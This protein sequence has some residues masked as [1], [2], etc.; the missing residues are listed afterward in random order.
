MGQKKKNNK[1]TDQQNETKKDHETKTT[2]TTVVLKIDMHC[3]GCTSK[4]IRCLRGFQ[5]LKLTLPVEGVEKLDVEK[6]TGK[7]T[8]TGKVD[9][10]KLRDKLASKMKK[11]VDL[12]SPLP[13]ENKSQN[14]NKNKP[15][16]KKSKQKE[17]P[18]TTAVL[19]MELHC[20]GCIERIRKT[21]SKAKGVYHVEIDK[22][23]ETVTV[24]GTM[25]VKALAGSLTERLKRKVEV[26]PTKKEKGNEKDGDKKEKDGDKKENDGGK[27]NKQ[28]GEG[29]GG[30]KKGEND[31]GDGKG[32]ME[33]LT[34][35]CGY[36]YG[37]G[38]S[39]FGYEDGGYNNGSVNMMQLN[40][41]QIFS[42]EN[43]NACSVM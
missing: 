39:F 23:K 24:K 10:A 8:I 17:P 2:P 27:K 1:N 33:N 6:D 5:A 40:A 38:Y 35:G 19:K 29:G 9:P 20:Q 42:D 12:I 14:D 11:K 26:V 31:G 15:D 30:N 43:P 18:E 3:D 4:I 37:Y 13:K 34:P 16:D 36:G 7:L 22:E 41:P 25:D 21:V 32:K 28:K